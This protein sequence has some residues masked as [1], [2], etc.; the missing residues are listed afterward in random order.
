[1]HMMTDQ[2]IYKKYRERVDHFRDID[3]RELVFQNRVLIPFLE[4]LFH[5]DK[6]LEAVD[7]STQTKE[8]KEQDPSQ[9][10]SFDEGASSPDLLI[11]RNWRLCN[12]GDTNIQYLATIEVKSPDGKE[13]I[14]DKEPE[15]VC[16]YLKKE[17]RIGKQLRFHLQAKAHPD[18]ILTDCLRWQFFTRWDTEP[19]P[20]KDREL[21]P[22]LDIV[23]WDNIAG[24][25]RED[26]EW[27]KL[28]DELRKIAKLPIT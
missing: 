21:T 28:C 2:D 22:S 13:A 23:L 18:V 16:A 8:D 5:K 25:W 15:E 11:A 19:A 24:E 6:N 10:R 27:E 14:Y 9:Y 1:M 3:I 4:V 20:Q 26:G 12:R 7:I 17:K